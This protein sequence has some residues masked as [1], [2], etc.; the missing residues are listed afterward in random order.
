MVPFCVQ[1]VLRTGCGLQRVIGDDLA[2][3]VG[4]SRFFAPAADCNSNCCLAMR[5]SRNAFSRFFAPGAGG[6]RR[7]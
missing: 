7:A 4:F 2:D 6:G 3:R 5:R 1:P